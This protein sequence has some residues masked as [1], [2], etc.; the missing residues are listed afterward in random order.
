MN[1][2]NRVAVI[3]LNYNSSEETIHLIESIR[4]YEKDY[5][6]IVVDNASR[7]EE[8][9]KLVRMEKRD[10]LELICSDENTGYAAGNNVGLKQALKEGYQ[11]FLI[12]NSDTEIIH[13]DTIGTMRKRMVQLGAGALGPKL[14]DAKGKVDSGIIIDNKMGRTRK[15]ET[16]KATECRSVIGAFLMLSKKLIQEIGFLPEEYFLY[17]EETDYLVQAHKHYQ[18]VIYD[19][20]IEVIHRHGS[21]TGGVWDYYFNRNTIYFAKKVHGTSAIVLAVFHFMKSVYLTGMLLT[22]KQI[23]T[24]KKR[25]ICLTWRGYL[26]GM[27]SKM[28]RNDHL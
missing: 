19:P 25:A 22:G 20:S 26:D 6:L 23:R 7:M 27:R 14:L 11:Y 17:R 12:A 2:E 3:I 13:P 15:Q 18:K 5:H 24:D 10:D 4:K 9:E 28:G 8:K 16:S 21:T 1:Q